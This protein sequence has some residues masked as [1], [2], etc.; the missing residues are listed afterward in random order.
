MCL[1]ASKHLIRTWPDVQM[2][3]LISCNHNSMWWS[4][5]SALQAANQSLD[6]QSDFDR[7]LFRWVEYEGP[8]QQTH[9]CPG[10]RQADPPERTFIMFLPKD[11]LCLWDDF[12]HEETQKSRMLKTLYEQNRNCFVSWAHLNDVNWHQAVSYIIEDGC[13]GLNFH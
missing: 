9:W 2:R 12:V 11:L 8:R 1:H 7:F 5:S 13:C 10:Q 3:L 4:Q 6:W